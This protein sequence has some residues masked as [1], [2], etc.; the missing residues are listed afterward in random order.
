MNTKVIFVPPSPHVKMFKYG[1]QIQFP[2]LPLPNKNLCWEEVPR[3]LVC[4]NVLG[5]NCFLCRWKFMIVVRCKV[6]TKMK[7]KENLLI[8]KWY[9]FDKH[10]RKRKNEQGMKV[11]D[12]KCVHIKNKL[13]D[14]SMNQLFILE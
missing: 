5:R 12:A 6:C 9:S 10:A 7:H 13:T 2:F 14:V 8:T 3:C 11:V 4:E 1:M